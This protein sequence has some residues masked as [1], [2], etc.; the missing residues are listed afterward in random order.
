[1]LKPKS[2]HTG[3]NKKPQGDWHVSNTSL[4]MGDYYGTGIKNPT[5]KIRDGFGGPTMP[6]V[7]TKKPPTKLA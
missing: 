6:S 7:K 5:G 2:A 3:Q 4:G 1:M